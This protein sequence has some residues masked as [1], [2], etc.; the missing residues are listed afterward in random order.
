MSKYSEYTLDSDPPYVESEDNLIGCRVSLPHLGEMQEVVVKRR[1][2]NEDGTL[3]GTANN[4]P[5]LDTRIYEV[6]LQD[7]LYEEYSTNVLL[8]NV[9][10]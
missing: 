10:A 6:E 4:N 2:R 5:M 8:E 7:G 9:H 1:K 3:V